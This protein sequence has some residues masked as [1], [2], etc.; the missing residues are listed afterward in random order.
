MAENLPD[1]SLLTVEQLLNLAMAAT[2]K[3]TVADRQLSV[4]ASLARICLERN[5]PAMAHE[6]VIKVLASV[7]VNNLE[8]REIY[9]LIDDQARDGR[10]FNCRSRA[11]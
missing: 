8:Q 11:K 3:L 5:M 2:D 7:K 10:S 6:A 9:Y 1:R 4:Y